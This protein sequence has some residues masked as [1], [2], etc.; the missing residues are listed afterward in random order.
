M[1]KVALVC[2]SGGH[3]TQLLILRDF[4]ADKARF[5]VTFDKI[6]AVSQLQGEVFY[7][8]FHPTNRNI[9]NLLRNCGLALK[10][11]WKERPSMIVSS[12]AAIAVP[13]FYF[14][15]L[16]GARTVYIEVYDRID[17]PTLTGKLIY[18]V[19]DDFYVQWEEQRQYYPKAILVGE[20]L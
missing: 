18:P 12:G 1:K 6:D 13:F 16:F 4:W 11:L 7:P 10:L 2:S 19:T 8:C 5:W 14:G 20:L 15:K 3:L 17:G 9:K